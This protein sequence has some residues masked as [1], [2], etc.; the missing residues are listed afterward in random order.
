MKTLPE[1][2]LWLKQPDHI[3]IIL[4]EVEDILNGGTAPIY[5][6]NKAFTSTATDTPANTYYEA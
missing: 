2:V 6:S 1:I 5:L 4:V 3:R